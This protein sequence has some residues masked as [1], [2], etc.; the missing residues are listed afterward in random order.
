MTGKHEPLRSTGEG[1]WRSR[2]PRRRSGLPL[3]LAIL[4]AIALF[5]LA[6]AAVDALR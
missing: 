1:A 2:Q 4:S 5:V 6:A 3:A